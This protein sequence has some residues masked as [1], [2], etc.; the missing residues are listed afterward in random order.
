MDGPARRSWQPNWSP[1]LEPKHWNEPA[2]SCTPN[3]WLSTAARQVLLNA[4]LERAQ[5]CSCTRLFAF[6]RW[7]GHPAD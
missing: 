2:G 4:A 3:P 7:P 5:R 1:A 6:C